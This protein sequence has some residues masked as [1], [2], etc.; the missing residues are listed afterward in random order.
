V[1]FWKKNW[2]SSISIFLKIIHNF[3]QLFDK[4]FTQ[5]NKTQHKT[6]ISDIFI[7]KK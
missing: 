5:Y 3:P 1:E 6:S 7:L 4:I 2:I